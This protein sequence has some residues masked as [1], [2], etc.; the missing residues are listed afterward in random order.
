MKIFW[1]F[2]PQEI[3]FTSLL[4]KSGLY[5]CFINI[6]WQKWQC[7]SFWQ[8]LPP[9][10]R[11]TSSRCPETPCKKSRY[12]ETALLELQYEMV[13]AE[14]SPPAI[15]TKFTDM[16]EK[17][18]WIL[19]P[20][21]WQMTPWLQLVS[22]GAKQ[23]SHWVLIESWTHRIM[24]AV[25]NYSGPSRGKLEQNLV[26]GGGCCS[27]KTLKYVALGLDSRRKWQALGS[28][29]W[30]LER[31]KRPL[32][33]PGRPGGSR[34]RRL[35][36]SDPGLQLRGKKHLTLTNW[37]IWPTRFPGKMLTMPFAFFEPLITCEQREKK[38]KKRKNKKEFYSVSFGLTESL[39]DLGEEWA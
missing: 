27:N 34:F 24:I 14:P 20:A 2:S 18:S 5:G 21:S 16:R 1:H 29:W 6:L 11:K 10:S 33:K 22:C 9:L 12:S 19:R 32:V 8:F 39:G 28:L 38:L 23:L 26:L 4:L 36:R 25:F 30:K 15:P 13:L 17:P 35:E 37:W 7:A 3:K 31:L